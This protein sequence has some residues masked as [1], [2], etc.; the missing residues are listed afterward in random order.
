MLVDVDVDVHVDVDVDDRFDPA[1][2]LAHERL[3]VYQRSVEFLAR[4]VAILERLPSGTSVLADQLRRASLSVPLNIAEG[5]GKANEADR[6][7][8]YQ[9][10]RGSA[11]ECGAIL[12]ACLVLRVADTQAVLEGKR[13]LVR[14]V[15][16]LSRMCR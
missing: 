9:I 4:S 1:V 12:D 2:T 15:S 7:R 10:A 11:T 6:R 5:V 8:Y 16:M 3:D 13:L 14:V